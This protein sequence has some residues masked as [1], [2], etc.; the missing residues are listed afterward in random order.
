MHV[1]I[2]SSDK[3]FIGINR[4]CKIAFAITAGVNMLVTSAVVF[5]HKK[6]KTQVSSYFGLLEMLLVYVVFFFMETD[7]E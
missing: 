3:V 1:S 7:A 2:V 6:N 4:Y 5:A